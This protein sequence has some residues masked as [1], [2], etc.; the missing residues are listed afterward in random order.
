MKSANG[1]RRL[2]SDLGIVAGIF[3]PSQELEPLATVQ[4]SDGDE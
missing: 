3:A 1:A 4:L 2:I